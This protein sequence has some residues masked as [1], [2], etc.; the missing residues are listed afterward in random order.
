MLVDPAT[1]KVRVTRVVQAFDAGA[2]TNPQNLKSQNMGAII[3]GL[4][5]LLR[6][7]MEFEDGKITNASFW[8]YGVPRM[9]DLP[10]IEVHLI[11]QPDIPSAGAGETPLIV[12]TPAVRNAVFDAT[13]QWLRD[14]P[15]RLNR[16]KI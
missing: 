7:A 10:Q 9:S 16:L 5:P 8:K 14:L 4:G 15:L 2:I 1:G 3:M 13:K 11:N 6:E 12:V